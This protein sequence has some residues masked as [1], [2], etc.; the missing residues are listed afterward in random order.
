MSP[1]FPRLS[2]RKNL[3]FLN[4]GKFHL[5]QLYL[6]VFR[7]IQRLKTNILKAFLIIL[8]GRL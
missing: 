8:L 4:A 1:D 7:E 3:A 6:R 2:S 5:L